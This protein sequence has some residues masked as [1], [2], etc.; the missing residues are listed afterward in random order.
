MGLLDDAELSIRAA[1]AV[2]GSNRCE[3]TLGTEA[4]AMCQ[5][6][7]RAMAEVR[8]EAADRLDEAEADAQFLADAFPLN[9]EVCGATQKD[10]KTHA[11]V[12][13][14]RGGRDDD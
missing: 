13:E 11:I 8:D 3:N 6:V 5:D 4:C 1:Q 10:S 2:H 9:C 12:R 14:W 7:Q